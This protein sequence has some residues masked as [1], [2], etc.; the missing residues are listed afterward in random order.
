M[1]RRVYGLFF[2]LALILVEKSCFAEYNDTK[3]HKVKIACAGT[4]AAF[5]LS[6]P[7]KHEEV[8]I[9]EVN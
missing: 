7:P 5:D 6:A 8:A 4:K 3:G 1:H 2:D 9:Y